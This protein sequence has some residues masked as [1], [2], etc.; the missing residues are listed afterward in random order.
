MEP[1]DN[2]FISI[3]IPAGNAQ[4]VLELCLKAIFSSVK[5]NFEV[6]IVDDASDDG[7]SD[8]TERFPCKLI[9]LDR[10]SGPAAARNKGVDI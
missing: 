4:A 7:L 8:I 3:V 10:K 6:I 9:R 2:P 5:N 1:L